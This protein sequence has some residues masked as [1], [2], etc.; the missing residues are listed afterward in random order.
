MKPGKIFVSKLFMALSACAAV[1]PPRHAPEPFWECTLGQSGRDAFTA[2]ARLDE[3]GRQVSV[4]WLWF[5]RGEPISLGL[6]GGINADR[7]PDPIDSSFSVHWRGVRPPGTQLPVLRLELT[8]NPNW[9]GWMLYVPFAGELASGGD[10]YTLTASWADT[11]AF[12]RGADKLTL[13]LR[14]R[15]GRIVAR[16][17]LPR[18]TLAHA[19]EAV[20]AGL[21]QL[22]AKISHYRQECNYIEGLDLLSLPVG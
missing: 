19:D 5:L 9:G 3:Q 21:R 20:R 16:Q 15:T 22:D 14:D 13:L 18:E 1:P 6:A 2:N 7:S 8:S 4:S 10:A 12:A 11:L 17:P